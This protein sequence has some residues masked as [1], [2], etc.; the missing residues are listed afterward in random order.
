M[1][2]M[3]FSHLFKPTQEIHQGASGNTRKLL[4]RE[5]NVNSQTDGSVPRGPNEIRHFEVIPQQPNPF[6]MKPYLSGAI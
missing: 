2:A 5:R 4:S 6:T 1:S 3:E